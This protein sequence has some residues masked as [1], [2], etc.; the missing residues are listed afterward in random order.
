M[1][2]HLSY[3]NRKK[4]KMLEKRVKKLEEQLEK[5]NKAIINLIM[6]VCGS[7]QKSL[8]TLQSAINN[9]PITHTYIPSDHLCTCNAVDRLHKYYNPSL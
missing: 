4:I 9:I 7:P 3:Q 6:I 1:K 8:S 2:D 5:Q